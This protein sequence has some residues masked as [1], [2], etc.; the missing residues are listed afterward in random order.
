MNIKQKTATAMS[1]MMLASLTACGTETAEIT[2]EEETLASNSEEI[3]DVLT[4]SL[5][6]GSETDA[7]KEETVY[8]IADANGNAQDTIVSEWL[9]NTDKKDTIEDVSKLSDIENVSG[10]ETFKQNGTKLT[11]QAGGNDIYYQGH[12]SEASPVSVKVTYQLDGKDVSADELLGQSGHVKI[13]Y[14]YSKVWRCLY[15]FYHGNR[16]DS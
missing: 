9:K 11:W 13:R 12:S 4:D 15:T 5:G 8:V 10:D 1:I 16:S 2:T 14:E 3:T 6:I 7:D